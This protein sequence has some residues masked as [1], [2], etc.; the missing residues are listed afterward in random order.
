MRNVDERTIAVVDVETTGLAPRRNRIVE[1]AVVLMSADGTIQGEFETLLNP[2][3]DVGPTRVHGITAGQVLRAPKFAEVAGEIA[4]LLNP[5]FIVAGH[6]V[7]FDKNFL[8]AEFD[9]ID[10]Q[11]PELSVLCTCRLVGRQNLKSACDEFGVKFIGDHH[12]AIVDARNTAALLHHLIDAEI[13]DW[14]LLQAHPGAWPEVRR[15]TFEPVTRDRVES[16]G[17]AEPTPTLLQRLSSKS[18][19]DVESTL[20]QLLDYLLFLDRIL[21]D[22][23]ITSDERETASEFL[24]DLGLT[25]VQAAA[26]HRMYLQYLAVAALADGVLS[27]SEREDLRS[28][29]NLLDVPYQMVDQ[30]LEAATLQLSLAQRE[31]ARE[32]VEK[33]AFRGRTVCFTGELQSNI[34]GEPISRSLAQVLAERAG[35]VPANSVTKKLNFLVVAD[36]DTQSGKAKKARAYGT[37]IIAEADF[38]QMVGVAVD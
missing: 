9:R 31:A 29:A 38:W 2:E 17:R 36:V 34:N 11:M 10:V 12:R 26:A 30:M 13:V 5:R 32:D 33:A 27:E 25:R 24:A 8:R 3:R 18:S 7:S 14:S 23:L 1:I 4:A 21:E 28:V 15:R 19:H 6:N 35:M 22:R 16:A 37:R 20:P